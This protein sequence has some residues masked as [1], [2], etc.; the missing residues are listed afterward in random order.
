MSKKKKKDKR[1]KIKHSFDLVVA[2]K[3]DF[4]EFKGYKEGGGKI[5]QTKTGVPYWCINSKGEIENENYI[6]KDTTDKETFALLLANEQIL[7]TK[8]HFKK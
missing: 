5:W 2:K 3:S 6:F 7:I 8:P 4:L 1:K